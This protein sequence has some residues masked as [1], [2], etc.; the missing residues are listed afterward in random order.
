VARPDPPHVPSHDDGL[1]ER[2]RLLVADAVASTR[3]P[4]SLREGLEAQRARAAAPRRRRLLLPAGATAVVAAAIAAIVLAAGGPSAPSALG[5]AQL[6][7]RGPALPAPAQD[8]R[9]PQRL[10]AEVDGV[11]FPDWG[12][13]FG[14]RAS[15][16]RSDELGGRA[17]RT[18]Y[19]AAGGAQAAYTIVAGDA[20]EAPQGAQAY[21]VGGAR[22]WTLDRQGRRVVV[23]ERDGH[24]CIVS[25]PRA[26]P[27]RR[28]LE[29]AAW[30][31]D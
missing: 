28:L 9:A 1:A 4:Q 7:T 27:E 2:G 11:V 12:Q 15:G 19:Y 3:A 13:A 23:W 20:L 10:R 8:V 29:L 22:F 26:V 16:A 14:W 17:T 24:T 18:V 6:A 21:E 5:A 25:A 31:A 30:R